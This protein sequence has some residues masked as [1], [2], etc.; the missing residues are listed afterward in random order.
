[1]Q[2]PPAALNRAGSL[3]ALP[4]PSQEGDGKDREEELLTSS[5][6]NLGSKKDS[7]RGSRYRLTLDKVDNLLKAIY[8]TLEIEEE[9]VHSSLV[10]SIN[11]G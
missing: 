4:E 10:D 3:P 7:S 2:G 8:D 5:Q 6:V 11:L 1:M 9:K